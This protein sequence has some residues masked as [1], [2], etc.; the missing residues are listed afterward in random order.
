MTRHTHGPETGLP[1]IVVLLFLAERSF[2][3][4]GHM[5][6]CVFSGVRGHV[7]FM[8]ESPGRAWFFQGIFLVPYGHLQ[9]LLML[10][11]GRETAGVLRV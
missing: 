5:P 8:L 11:M 6:G 10:R 1:A 9:V 7:L 4:E 3:R 2:A